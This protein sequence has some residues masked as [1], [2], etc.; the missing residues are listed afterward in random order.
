L[1][2]VGRAAAAPTEK[3]PQLSDLR[4]CVTGDT[5]VVLAD[6]QRVPIRDLVGTTPEVVAMTAPE[7]MLTGARSDKVWRVGR[8]PVYRV[9]LASGRSIRC[10]LRHRLWGAEGWVR[11]RDL[12]VGDRLAI[13]RRLPEPASPAEWPDDRV[14]LLG[15]LIGDGSYLQNAPMR[16]TTASEENSAAVSDAA[17]REFGCEVKRYR[18]RRAWHQLLIS[19]NGNRWA[20]AGVNAWLRELGIFGQRSHQK[21]VPDAAF[22]LSNLQL[23]LL[24][25]HLWATDGT[26][27]P[28]KSARGGHTVAYSTNSARLA[29]DVASLLLRFGIVARL[30]TVHKAGYRP[31]LF[32]DVSGAAAQR[33]FLDAVGAF[34]PRVAAAE[35]LRR[36]VSGTVANTNVDTLPASYF[37]RARGLMRE[38]QITTRAMCAIRGTA[39]GGS[40]HFRFSPSRNLLAEYGQVLEDGILMEQAGND[41][42]W[43]RIVS[44]D[45]DGEEDVFDL[46]VP[47]PAS[48]LADGIISHNSGGLEQDADIVMFIFREEEY[49][50]SDENRGVAELIIGKQ[51]NGPTGTIK[52]AFLK[53]YTR[54]ENLMPGY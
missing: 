10:T 20:P 5:L 14:A 47:G 9:R 15:Q 53:E 43:D 29:S 50:P 6:G 31:G 12:R 39:Y 38:R 23:G 24:L 45:A 51:R 32:V 49:K 21:R 13:A 28:R 41:L 7:G 30:Y 54:F 34:G 11:L 18:G 1:P 36:V 3:R 46:T 8:R 42:F 40:S 27:S 19:G 2:P 37:D 25:R 16:Y 17:R 35:R 22:R 33:V 48:W 44:I 4:E 26:I 52:L